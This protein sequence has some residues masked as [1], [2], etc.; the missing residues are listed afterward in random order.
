MSKKSS[1]ICGGHLFKFPYAQRHPHD[2]NSEWRAFLQALLT[3]SS[4]E[5]HLQQDFK[6]E[7]LC[8][9]LSQV[10]TNYETES[11]KQKS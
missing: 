1:I 7:T 8:D 2:S 9:K 3:F 6:N 4:N 10:V 5:K 11:D